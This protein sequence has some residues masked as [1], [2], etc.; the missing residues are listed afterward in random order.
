MRE[1]AMVDFF[2]FLLFN[3][4]YSAKKR[5]RS[6]TAIRNAPARNFRANAVF[7]HALSQQVQIIAVQ[8]L[9]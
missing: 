9:D 2:P 5:I 6:A 4:F 1:V 7:A 8:T 3:N